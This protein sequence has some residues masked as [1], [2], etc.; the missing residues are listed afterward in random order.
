MPN[1]INCLKRPEYVLRPRQILSRLRRMI[2]SVPETE[3]VALPWGSPIKARLRDHIGNEII[4]HGIFD[5]IVPETIARLLDPGETALDIGANI[6]QNASMMATASG[7][8]GKVIAFEPHPDVFAELQQNVARWTD[9]WLA[10]IDIRQVA[11]GDRTGTTLLFEGDDFS[12][13][14]GS[15]TLTKPPNGGKPHETPIER[16][17]DCLQDDQRIGLG[18]L[19]VE[20]G[21][22][23]VLKGALNT[24]KRKGIRDLIYEDFAEQPSSLAKQ[25]KEASFTL[26][27]LEQGW[28][29]PFIHPMENDWIPPKAF[30]FNFLA[31]LDPDRA[32]HRFQSRGWL[33]LKSTAYWLRRHRKS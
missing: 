25:L 12:Y 8:F 4:W 18:K 13:N 22:P 11:L 27:A 26:F 31:T 10:P 20:G 9:H 24:L 21:E 3:T 30:S 2:S 28:S 7:R 5:K 16:L 14:R 1:I 33:S 23:A 17:D 29:K 32:I 15:A 19:D 6:G